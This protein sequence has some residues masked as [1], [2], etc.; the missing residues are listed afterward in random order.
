MTA[1][2]DPPHRNGGDRHSGARLLA[3]ALAACVALAAC[4]EKPPAL[5]PLSPQDVVLAFGDSLTFGTGAGPGE[6]YPAV[7]ERLIGRKVVAAGVPG[8][9]SASGR[10]RLAGALDA[11]A[12][13]LL[14]LCHGG[15]DLLRRLDEGELAENLRAMIGLARSRGVGVVLV[16]VPKPGLFPDAHPVYAAVAGELRV[17]LERDALKAILTD[18]AL[19]SD[20]IHPNARGYARLAEAVANLLRAA[21]AL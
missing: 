14:I 19:K 17:P 3:L 21:K 9:V 5:P 12:P 6:S 8:E 2:S 16:A 15:N 7:L 10:A 4:G 11:A 20:P 13:T 1:V 18:N